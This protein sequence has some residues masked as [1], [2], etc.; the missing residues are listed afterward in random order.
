VTR[1][2]L[3]TLTEYFDGWTALH[4]GYDPRS[5]WL[6]TFWLTLTYRVTVPLARRSVPPDLVTLGGLVTCGVVVILG[7]VGGRWPLL[8]VAV[9]V[10]SGLLDNMDGA[11][12]VLTGQAT[13]FGA[14]LDSLVDRAGEG[15]YLVA[16]WA[17]G[18]PVWL[19]IV[20]GAITMQQEY[21][22][23]KAM[24][25]GMADIGVVTLWERPTRIIVTA[26]FLAGCGLFPA[27]AERWA[28]LAA[29]VWCV[30]GWVGFVHFMT[31]VYRRL[32]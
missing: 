28:T 2:E 20:G 7:V 22:R 19:C 8:A 1:R 23:A 16:L 13:R 3:P 21:A 18:A 30:L 15:L 27:V 11:V 5:S 17:L 31:V 29:A 24:A 10:A 14:V 25:A 9:V 32:R 6:V 4:G 26:A 12:A